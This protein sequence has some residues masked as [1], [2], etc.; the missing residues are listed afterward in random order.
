M[1]LTFKKT[2]IWAAYSGWIFTAGF[3][4]AVCPWTGG[5]IPALL[6][7]T[8]T[9]EV[10]KAFFTARRLNIQIGAILGMVFSAFYYVW[11]GAIA[12]LLRRT[13]NGR[14]PILTYTMLGAIG[15]AVF[16]SV[17]YFFVMGFC[18]YR[19][20]SIDPVLLRHFN[21]F[22]YIQLEFEVFPL[23]LW[24]IVIGLS[25]MLD[26]SVRPVF[27][28]W[29]AWVNF[30]YAGLVMSGQFMILF[31][32]GPLAYNGVLALYWPALVF[33]TWLCVMSVAMIKS[34]KADAG[35][36]PEVECSQDYYL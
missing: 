3:L 34:I 26:K 16:N 18:A 23:S 24:A 12:A 25:I 2:H 28:R 27:P 11:G 5:T 7:P 13:E 8:D 32:T 6:S 15:V 19:V 9:P 1:A 35:V 30:W 29:V 10:V 4:L 20:E 31:K 17:L 33:F 22:L 36:R 14:P 21:D